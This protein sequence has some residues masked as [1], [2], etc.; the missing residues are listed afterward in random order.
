MAL[1][2]LEK[3]NP[4][5]HRYRHDLESFFFVLVWF[6]AVFEPEKHQFRHLS[7]WES[8]NLYVIGRNKWAF[9][10]QEQERRDVFAS[11]HPDYAQLVDTWVR[12]LRTKFHHVALLSHNIIFLAE[13]LNM[14]IEGGDL[15]EATSFEAQI[16]QTKAQR[17]EVMTYEIFMRS[18][19]LPAS[20]PQ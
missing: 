14:A 19:Q 20:G 10:S 15:E 18:L 3:G 5:L 1:D 9:I 8:P 6:C 11:T 17:S 12:S 16:A 7:D 13:R 2:L 4:P